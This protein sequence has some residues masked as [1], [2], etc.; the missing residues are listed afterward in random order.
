MP[1]IFEGANGV[2]YKKNTPGEA[3][4]KKQLTQAVEHS[5]SLQHNIDDIIGASSL[6]SE[7]LKISTEVKTIRDEIKAAQSDISTMQAANSKLEHLEAS[8][9]YN[10]WFFKNSTYKFMEYDSFENDKK[11]FHGVLKNNSLV[12][13]NPS[14]YSIYRTV[15]YVPQLGGPILRYMMHVEYNIA[16]GGGLTVEIS[17]NDGQNYHMVLSTIEQPSIAHYYQY[18]D[19]CDCDNNVPEMDA[20]SFIVRF[21]LLAN[22]HGAGVSVSSFGILLS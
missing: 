18:P 14:A 10:S 19:F 12:P 21:R 6:K 3:L 17:F 2:W 8:L 11:L 4:A 13:E 22:Q 9:F 20:H 16:E 7:L 15:K 5:N 1:I